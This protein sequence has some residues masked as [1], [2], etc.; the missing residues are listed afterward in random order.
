MSE[1]KKNKQGSSAE[2]CFHPARAVNNQSCKKCNNHQKR[3]KR[4]EIGNKTNSAYACRAIT[5]T[6]TLVTS[7]GMHLIK[8][9]KNYK[10]NS[11]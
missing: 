4:E 5:E 6:L 3:A 8:A 10:F 2:P 9:G 1:T 11:I 7:D